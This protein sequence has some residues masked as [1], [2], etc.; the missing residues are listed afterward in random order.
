MRISCISRLTF[1]DEEDIPLKV[2][3]LRNVIDNRSSDHTSTSKPSTPKPIDSSRSRSTPTKDSNVTIISNRSSI[4]TRVS[5]KTQNSVTFLE[6]QENLE[7][8]SRIPVST[9][10]RRRRSSAGNTPYRASSSTGTGPLKATSDD[11]LPS[12]PS[13]PHLYSLPGSQEPSPL[14]PGSLNAQ[15]PSPPIPITNTTNTTTS[16]V[17][18][19]KGR[20]RR[21]IT[22]SKTKK[23]VKKTVTT[24]GG[25]DSVQVPQGI[26][27]TH[28]HLIASSRLSH[29]CYNLVTWL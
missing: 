4:G 24:D 20:K 26:K 2:T 1:T 15:E 25:K 9:A 23:R 7:H 12:P 19:P 10:S 13:P 21:R 3:P 6:D 5:S 28:C 18:V 14:L 17:S 29:G 16:T 11:E 8:S 22:Y 27:S